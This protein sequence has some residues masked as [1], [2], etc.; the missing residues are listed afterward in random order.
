MPRSAGTFSWVD[1]CLAVR[2]QP[3]LGPSGDQ[4]AVRCA[5]SAAPGGIEA[6]RRVSGRH[7]EVDDREV[8]KHLPDELDQLGGRAGFA[9]D[10]EARAAQQARQSSRSRTSSSASTTQVRL[11]LTASDM[12]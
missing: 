12:G 11:V 8:G 6:F 5:L 10:L 7:P 2:Y 4:F 9:D 3:E 1:P